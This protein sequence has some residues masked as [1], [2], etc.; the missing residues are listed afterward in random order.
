MAFALAGVVV[1]VFL[2]SSGFFAL[3]VVLRRRVR[4]RLEGRDAESPVN[5]LGRLVLPTVDDVRWRGSKALMRF[6]EGRS[7]PVEVGDGNR[8]YI[9]GRQLPHS[10]Q[11]DR[12]CREVVA[13]ARQRR[14][15]SLSERMER[16][17]E[18]T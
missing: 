17:I 15:E 2:G 18:D 5:V 4:V 8:L 12:Y 9:E 6:G 16:V 14:L 3:L 1:G 7:A 11:A 10:P 13:A